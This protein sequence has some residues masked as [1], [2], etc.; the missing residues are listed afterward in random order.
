MITEMWIN[1]RSSARE[2]IKWPFGKPTCVVHG[3]QSALL[4]SGLIIP[5]QATASQ[6]VHASDFLSWR[7]CS[8]TLRAPAQ[9]GL[10]PLSP[11]PASSPVANTNTT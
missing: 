10:Q 7:C 11:Q 8:N 9:P 3:G 2:N 6:D 1:L 5:C 4:F